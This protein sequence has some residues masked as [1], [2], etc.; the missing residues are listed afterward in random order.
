[1]YRAAKVYIGKGMF[2]THHRCTTS[3]NWS[4]VRARCLHLY[5]Y[6]PSWQNMTAS[7]ATADCNLNFGNMARCLVMNFTMSLPALHQVH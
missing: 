6:I 1:M 2:L 3:R 5:S 7:R 4:K